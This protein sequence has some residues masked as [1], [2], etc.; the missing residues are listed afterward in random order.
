MSKLLIEI[1][2][3]QGFF[4][5]LSKQNGKYAY[6]ITDFIANNPYESS[7]IYKTAK[8]ALKSGLNL[9]FK[10]NRVNKNNVTI[11]ENKNSIKIYELIK[12]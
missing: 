3:N 11:E 10:I 2:A 7:Y 4:P 8:S 9:I 5:K 12:I 6:K 1:T